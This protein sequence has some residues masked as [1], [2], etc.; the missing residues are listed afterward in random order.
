MGGGGGDGNGN[1]VCRPCVD[2]VTYHDNL[3]NSMKI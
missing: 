1:E 2:M 3:K